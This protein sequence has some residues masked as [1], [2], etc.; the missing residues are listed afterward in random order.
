M[1]Q[2]APREK[3]TVRAS[4]VKDVFHSAN[5]VDTIPGA[6][7][8]G[9]PSGRV[10]DTTGTAAVADFAAW[11]ASGPARSTASSTMINEQHISRARPDEAMVIDAQD[12][13]IFMGI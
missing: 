6:N 10:S 12:L 11:P 7:S 5:I 1:V 13:L 9:M 2:N 3:K 8:D 4:G